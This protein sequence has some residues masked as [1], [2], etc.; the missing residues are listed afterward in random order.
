MA[1]SQAELMAKIRE[2]QTDTS[3]SDDEKAK[4]RQ[5]LLSGKWGSKPTDDNKE[6][7]KTAG[8]TP[9]GPPLELQ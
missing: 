1:V 4:R 6:N 5:E 9:P 3:L 8:V 2:I 7:S